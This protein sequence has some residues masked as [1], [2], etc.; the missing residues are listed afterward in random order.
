MQLK[1]FSRYWLVILVVV[2]ALL[3]AACGQDAETTQPAEVEAPIAE[4]T[5]APEPT[6]VPSETPTEVPTEEAVAEESAEGDDAAATAA[7]TAVAADEVAT[8]T[9]GPLTFV[10]DAARS[11][12]RFVIDEVL[13]GQPTTVTGVNSDVNGELLVDPS[14]PDATEIGVLTIGAGTFVTDNNQRNGAIRRFILQSGDHPT[15]TFAP[16]QITDM[17]DVVAV[18]DT[19]SFQVTGD[20]TIRDA[21]NSVTFDLT[22]VVV[23][24][25]ELQLSGSTQILREDYSISIPRVPFV[26][27][28]EEEVI[29][30]LDLVATAQ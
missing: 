3:L 21:T 15:I 5:S 18:G 19:L 8:S 14:N 17:P 9:A 12:V 10:I 30:E 7:P 20:L 25:S 16:T 26:A 1:S 2:L 6:E 23:S 28:V 29:L 24:E 11:E 22:A 4:A 27:S 13:R